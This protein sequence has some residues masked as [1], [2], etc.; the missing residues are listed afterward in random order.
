M[1]FGPPRSAERTDRLRALRKTKAGDTRCGS[2]G[3][4][5]ALL[6]AKPWGRRAAARPSSAARSGRK[7][8][9]AAGAEP[10]GA[11]RSVGPRL[12]P[13]SHSLY[14]VSRSVSRGGGTAGGLHPLSGAGAAGEGGRPVGTVRSG[15]E[16]PPPPPARPRRTCAAPG[17]KGC[18]RPGPLGGVRP[19]PLPPTSA[20]PSSRF[21]LHLRARVSPASLRRRPGAE[22][23]PEPLP[24]PAG[25]KRG[26]GDVMSIQAPT[27]RPRGGI[28]ERR[29]RREGVGHGCPSASRTRPARCAPLLHTPRGRNRDSPFLPP[30]PPLPTSAAH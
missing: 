22:R 6:D 2:I 27:Q 4:A 11:E 21:Y 24:P 3:E 13:R 14:L 5:K 12:A 1:K 30:A 8:R 26:E 16:E 10:Q 20:V 17:T 19:F 25:G 15:L 9:R 18:G 28:G 23:E 7:S 29:R